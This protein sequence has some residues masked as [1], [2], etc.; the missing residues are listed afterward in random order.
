M[1]N[2]DN[3]RPTKRTQHNQHDRLQHGGSI[4]MKKYRIIQLITLSKDGM[5]KET[6]HIQKNYGKIIPE[7]ITIHDDLIQTKNEAELLLEEIIKDKTTT[8]KYKTIKE[9]KK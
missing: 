1:D 2:M 5:Y 9:V 8:Y 3:K 4:H 6:Y 7:W